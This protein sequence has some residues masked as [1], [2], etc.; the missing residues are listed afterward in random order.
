[1]KHRHGGGKMKIAMVAGHAC[2]RVQKMALP[3]IEKGHD[4]HLVS[5][6]I[7]SFMERYSSF[8]M[9]LGVNH[10]INAIK[11]LSH[12]VDVFHCHNEPS[13]FVTMV[14]EHTDVPVILDV[15][16]S[17]VAR[18][19]NKEEEES[20]KGDNPI[21]RTSVEERN[22]FQLADALVFPSEPFA[23]QIMEYFRLTQPH[24]VL[25]SYVPRELF[26]YHANE[27]LG[28]LVYE[29]R[30][31]L[32]EDIEKNPQRSY[33]YCD[34]SELA[35]EAHEAGLQFNIYAV[36]SDEKM[37]KVYGDI[38]FLHSPKE[39]QALLPKVARHDWGLVGNS[40]PSPEW[41]VALPNK[42]FEYVACGVPVVAMNAAYCER[43]V[44]ET[45]IGIAVKSIAELKDR[46]GEHQECRNRL[47]KIRQKL[48]MD[49]NIKSLEDLYA[50]VVDN[51]GRE[52][53]EYFK[54]HVS[55]RRNICEVFREIH[56]LAETLEPGLGTTKERLQKIAL[57]GY[58]MGKKMNDKLF[59]YKHDWDD[60]MFDENYGWDWA[61]VKR[62]QIV[63]PESFSSAGPGACVRVGE[64]EIYKFG[65]EDILS[66]DVLKT[67][68][69]VGVQGD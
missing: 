38:A 57:E 62:G 35:K 66:G 63:D 18:W 17:D 16:D 39:F 22:N 64:Q 31:D 26:Q 55:P 69:K 5:K 24:I 60:G 52:K 33:K 7:P 30:V 58:F 10:F 43:F 8:S 29:G 6:K 44:V 61:K 40:F 20:R 4:V 51:Y 15:H 37:K 50:S 13:W 19:T 21:Y 34:Y 46:W 45:G 65:E 36:R 59:Q 23:E 11:N 48:T 67:R 49:N 41:D 25:P 3:L 32:V 53:F 2:I 47:L 42:M 9:S 14:K 27:Y 28:G 56:S 12:E 68:S 1:M 54:N